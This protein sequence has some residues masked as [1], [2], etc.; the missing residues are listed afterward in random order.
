MYLLAN[1]TAIVPF[2]PGFFGSP[3]SG[4]WLLPVALPNVRVGSAEL[5]LTNGKGNSPITGINVTH[6]DDSGLRTL[7]GGQY[8]IQ[9]DGYLAVE[10]CVAPPLL[11]EAPHSVGQMYAVLGTSADAQVQLQVLVNGSAYGPTLTFQ[12]GALVSNSV[13]GRTLPPRGQARRSRPQCFQWE[14]HLPERILRF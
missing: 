8:S 14:W 11:V 1:Q 7:S 6:N 12:A 13:P 2:P 3:Y 10:Q 5:F 9:V 4:S